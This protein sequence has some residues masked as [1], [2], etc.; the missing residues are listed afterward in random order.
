MGS[1][2]GVFV[3]VGGCGQPGDGRD[4]TPIATFATVGDDGAEGT[5]SSSGDAA[6]DSTTAQPASSGDAGFTGSGSDTGA[7]GDSTGAGPPIATCPPGD[8]LDCTPGP[9]RTVC[10]KIESCFAGLVGSA[11]QSTVDENPGWFQPVEGGTEVLDVDAFVTTVAEKVAAQGRCSIR[12][13]NDALGLEVGV[14]NDNEYAESFR[15]VTSGGL[16]R[17]GGGS[18]TATCWP[19]WF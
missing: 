12:D 5:A 6:A 17:F 7:P 13:P 2:F 10:E 4:S 15:L 1:L 16:V 18:C 8:P 19:A 3:I 9:G 14:K 11:V